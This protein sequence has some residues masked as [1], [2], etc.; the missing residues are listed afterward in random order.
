MNMPKPNLPTPEFHYNIHAR[1]IIKAIHTQDKAEFSIMDPTNTN[2]LV[3]GTLVYEDGL[4][5][6]SKLNPDSCK[7]F[8][9]RILS[10]VQ[11]WI[12]DQRIKSLAKTSP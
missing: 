10:D 9:N 11:S 2:L 6:Y 12:V 7:E 1:R 3:E 4:V 5:K 8:S